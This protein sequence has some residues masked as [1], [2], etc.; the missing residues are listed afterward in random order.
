VTQN[1][2]VNSE[3]RIPSLDGCRA[4]A[5]L[6]VLYYHLQF[7]PKG[8]FPKMVNW[9]VLGVFIFFVISGFLITSLLERERVRF[10]SISLKSFYV[11]RVFRI[12]PA[13]IICLIGIKVLATFGLTAVSDRA[14][15]FS[16][17]F[18]RN[19]HPGPYRILH[20]LW[21]L[22]VEEQFYLIWPFLF[23]TLSK[24]TAC[25]LLIGVII[26]APII[27][28]G[29]VLW[30]GH[31]L[32]DHTEQV[33]D[34]L[35]FGCLLALKQ[36]ELRDSSFYRWLAQSRV[37]LLLPFVTVAAYLLHRRI[38]TEA[39]AKSI[40]FLG[41]TLCIDILMFRSN[42][43]L[44]KVM[45]FR[46]VVWFGKISYSLYLWQ[47]VF[48]IVKTGDQPYAWFPINIAL[49]FL[50]AIGSFYL[51]EYP[52]IRMGREIVARRIRTTVQPPIYA[53]HC[54]EA[55]HAMASVSKANV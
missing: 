6:L 31:S 19:Y 38:L 39:F 52:S 35:A 28:V 5:I 7:S 50:C 54:S 26:A 49:A 18:L 55:G 14:L 53:G 25:R 47:Q 10:G 51:I 23:A 20:H 12:F 37:G 46:P 8:D 15:I 48:L 4:I 22:S 29:C 45:N 24:R 34:G 44:G 42:S 16:L 9:G 11:R 27:R 3:Q 33:A 36:K 32:L 21:S 1:L 41:I 43:P 40:V 13:L 30:L 2:T 17:S